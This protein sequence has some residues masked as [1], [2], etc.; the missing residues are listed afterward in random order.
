MTSCIYNTPVSAV[1][2]EN[3]EGFSETDRS[4]D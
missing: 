2:V 4:K 1:D 3:G